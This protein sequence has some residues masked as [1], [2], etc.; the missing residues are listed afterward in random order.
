V[1]AKQLFPADLN[2]VIQKFTARGYP[3]R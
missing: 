3:V 1:A 2:T